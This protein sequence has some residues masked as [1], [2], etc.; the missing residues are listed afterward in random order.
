MISSHVKKLL[1]T[2]LSASNRNACYGFGK[3]ALTYEDTLHY[4]SSVKKQIIIDN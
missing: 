1:Q 3:I 2:Y 4:I